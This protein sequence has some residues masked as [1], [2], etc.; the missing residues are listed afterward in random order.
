[1]RG[2][3]NFLAELHFGLRLRL[4]LLIALACIPLV[5]VNFLESSRE[6]KRALANWS[7]RAVRLSEAAS[8]QEELFIEQTRRLLA[9]MAVCA[10]EPE[11]CRRLMIQFLVRSPEYASL[12]LSNDSGTWLATAVRAS[13]PGLVRI[14]FKQLD[15]EELIPARRVSKSNSPTLNPTGQ[16]RAMGLLRSISYRRSRHPPSDSGQF[17]DTGLERSGPRF[18]GLMQAEALP[19]RALLDHSLQ[20]RA[21]TVE[22]CPLEEGNGAGNVQFGYPIVDNFGHLQALCFATCNWTNLPNTDIRLQ[23]PPRARF[24]EFAP[25]GLLLS[26]VPG[27]RP[28]N[29]APLPADFVLHQDMPPPASPVTVESPEGA[30][31]VYAFTERHSRLTG[32]PVI[33]VLGIPRALLLAEADRKQRQRLSLL[34]LAVGLALLF[35]WFGGH[36]VVIRPWQYLAWT[37]RRLAEGDFKARTGLNHGPDQVS[38]FAGTLDQ[39][40]EKLEQREEEGKGAAEKLRSLSQRL[41]EVQESERRH[42]ARELHDEIGQSLTVAEMNLQAAL[43]VTGQPALARR[44][45]E[46]MH[47][48]EHVLQQV[49]DLSLSLRPSILD[50]LGLEPALRWYI[51]RQAALAGFETHLCFESMEKRLEPVMETEC[52]RIA[53]EALTNIVRHAGAHTV[54]VELMVR[55]GTLHLTVS[56]DGSGFEVGEARTQ[57][58]RGASLG[59]LNMEERASLAGGGLEIHSRPG[60]GTQV[61]AWFPVKWR[62]ASEGEPLEP[63]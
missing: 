59:L 22:P 48:V 26:C 52:F 63:T 49:Q 30:A 61:R 62:A 16:A 3:L 45:Q 46:S 5:L 14:Q 21:F 20:E 57:A 31:Y 11:T 17:Y 44:L 15:C 34:A 35:A 42:I 43:R 4:G 51:Q 50:D 24:A 8:R 9:D 33:G 1:M 29:P 13:E 60:Q 37:A 53:Q 12:G 6:Q 25:A 28:D 58:L 23:L 41:V 10:H 38:Q 27:P 19:I 56:D 54:S 2:V 40:A 18:E 32:A 47:V 7:Q 36:L 39:I 55:N